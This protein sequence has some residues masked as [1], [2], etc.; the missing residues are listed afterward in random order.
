MKLSKRGEYGLRTLIKLGIAREVNREV[1][2][3]T[4]LAEIERLPLKFVEQIL[5]EVGPE[6]RKNWETRYLASLS[7]RTA[8]P[9]TVAMTV[10]P[11]AASCG[12]PRANTIAFG[13][14]R[15]DCVL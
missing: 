1:V 4:E 13:G 6:Y 15:R 9:I 8:R 7:R 2:S 10:P 3:A 14:S 11:I 12:L 5:A